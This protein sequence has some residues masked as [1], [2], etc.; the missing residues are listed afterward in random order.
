MDLT[1]IFDKGFFSSRTVWVSIGFDI[2]FAILT[3]LIAIF[4]MIPLEWAA[5]I[6][7]ALVAFQNQVMKIMRLITKTG[8][9]PANPQKRELIVKQNREAVEILTNKASL[10]RVN[11]NPINQPSNFSTHK[12]EFVIRPPA[13]ESNQPVLVQMLSIEDYFSNKISSPEVTN[14]IRAN[15]KVLVDRVNAL[16]DTFTKATGKVLVANPKT[17]TLVSGTTEGGFRLKNSTTGAPR[18]AHKEGKAVDIYDPDG[19]LDDWLN[20]DKLIQGAL[21]REAPIHTPRWAHL[22]TRSPASGNRSYN[23]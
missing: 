8:I 10:D 20:D 15:A 1:K 4:Q 12:E 19:F 21:Y 14:E 3:A 13:T 9:L 7:L 17:G 16:I 5:P 2:L 6:A 11:K 23:I 22:T 18:S